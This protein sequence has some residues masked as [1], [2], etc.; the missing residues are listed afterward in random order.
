MTKHGRWRLLRPGDAVLPG[1]PGLPARRRSARGADRHHDHDHH[2]APV[3]F[4]PAG[5]GDRG[6]PGCRQ[7]QHRQEPAHLQRPHEVQ[8]V[9][10][11][12]RSAAGHRA[13][14]AR[15][16]EAGECP[17]GRDSPR[18]R[19]R[20]SLGAGRRLRGRVRLGGWLRRRRCGC[21]GSAGNSRRQRREGLRRVGCRLRREG[22]DRERLA[23]GAR[24]AAAGPWGIGTGL[25]P[26]GSAGP[27]A[28]AASAGAG[29]SMASSSASSGSSSI[30]VRARARR[31]RERAAECR[32]RASNGR[33]WTPTAAAEPVDGATP[34]TS[35]VST[36]VPV[37]SD[38][39]AKLRPWPSSSPRTV[40]AGERPCR[41]SVTSWRGEAPS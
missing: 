6:L 14:G 8:R 40:S 3:G 11:R 30:D 24:L 4:L 1:V 33:R 25:A 31:R 20:Y 17:A 35:S 39:S 38:T 9:A 7:H 36:R 21:R 23:R 26:A 28:S 22:R 37:L 2:D 5:A 10:V 16:A 19:D 41:L 34:A 15:R 12:G 13:P 29:S 32:A 27:A 18:E